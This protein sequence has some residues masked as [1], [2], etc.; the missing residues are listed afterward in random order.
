MKKLIISLALLTSVNSFSQT[1]K[2]LF[3]DLNLGSRYGGATS[4]FSK[5]GPGFHLDGGVGYMFSNIIGIKGELGMDWFNA[6]SADETTEDRAG[7][8]RA[9]LMAVLGVSELAGFGTEKFALRLNLG[10]GLA[11]LSNPNWKDDR[12]ASGYEFTDPLLKGN[13]DMGHFIIGLNPQY[14]I[15]SSISVNA[16]I[17]FV[18]LL[19][20][21]YVV[22]RSTNVAVEGVQNIVNAS[23]GISYRLGQ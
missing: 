2:G 13:D 7:M 15:N 17:A 8:G 1:D 18:G 3:F 12:I 9:T 4:E 22:D 23:V 6:M 19:Q 21:S 11:S 16:N 14:H 5:M 20:Q 10:F